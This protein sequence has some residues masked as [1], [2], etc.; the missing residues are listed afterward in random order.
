M[1]IQYK[2]RRD[3]RDTSLYGKNSWFPMVS[4]YRGSAKKVTHKAK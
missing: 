2:K 4:G 1:Y 3:E